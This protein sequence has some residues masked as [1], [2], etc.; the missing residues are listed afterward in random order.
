[1]ANPRQYIIS[2]TVKKLAYTVLELQVVFNRG[3]R[4]RHG[5]W[6]MYLRAILFTFQISV[7]FTMYLWVGEEGGEEGLEKGGGG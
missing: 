5:N 1:M 7:D 3:K 2:K 4:G 6:F